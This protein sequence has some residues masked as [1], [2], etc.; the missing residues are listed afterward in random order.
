MSQ[1]LKVLADRG[2]EAKETYPV[3][4]TKRN[5]HFGIM[6]FSDAVNVAIQAE[7]KRLADVWPEIERLTDGA[8]KL[9]Q[10]LL[11]LMPTKGDA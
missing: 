7:R 9:Q 4:E 10:L 5:L 11:L 6:V 1:L 2:V 3:D 8:E